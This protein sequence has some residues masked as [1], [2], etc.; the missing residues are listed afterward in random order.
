VIEIHA[1]LE[2]SVAATKT[3]TAQLAVMA[4]LGAALS[5]DEQRLTELRRLPDALQVTLDRAAA[6]GP[7]AERYRYM[8]QCVVIGRG[9]NYATALELALKIKELTYIM[10]NA[11]SSADFRHGP[12]ATISERL[13]A[14]LI[15]P[16]GAA[17]DDML[18]LAQELRDRGAELLI[19]TDE[20]AAKPLATTLL[21]LAPELPEWLSPLAAIMPGQVL[22]LHLAQAK[23]FDPDKPRGLRKVTLTQ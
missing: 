5:R 8:E 19:V 21:P 4:L 6:V 20:A 3:Y 15:M 10:A 2:Q 23:G 22:A 16:G 13:P 9:Y 18:A 12:I 14:I 11:Y 7:R 17:F 1:G